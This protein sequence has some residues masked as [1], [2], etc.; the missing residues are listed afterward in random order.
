M[1]VDGSGMSLK[2]NFEIYMPLVKN[3]PQMQG[4]R[5]IMQL[6]PKVGNKS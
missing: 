2:P 4:S 3:P 5:P 6:L 1:K